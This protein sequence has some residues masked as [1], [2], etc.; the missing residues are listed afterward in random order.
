MKIQALH[1]IFLSFAL[2]A[3][4]NDGGSET[5]GDGPPDRLGPPDGYAQYPLNEPVGRG[6]L[7]AY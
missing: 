1:V 7:T 3:G 2:I 6:L 5:G 4:C